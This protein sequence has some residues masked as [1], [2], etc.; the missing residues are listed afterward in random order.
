[1]GN[2]YVLRTLLCSRRI[3]IQT[4]VVIYRPNHNFWL[5][6][7]LY[8]FLRIRPGNNFPVHT[9]FDETSEDGEVKSDDE[10]NDMVN[11]TAASGSKESEMLAGV[12]LGFVLY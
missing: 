12:P 10:F 1:M 2:R 8:F 4:I 11:G 6:E 9:W 5:S 3:E 7:S